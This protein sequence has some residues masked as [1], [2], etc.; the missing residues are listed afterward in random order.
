MDFDIVLVGGGLANGLLA[1][2]LSQ[3]RPDISVAIVEGGSRIGGNHIWSSLDHDLSPEQRAW[4]EPLIAHR[5]QEY[6]VRFPKR[7]RTLKAGYRTATSG[8]LAD[9]MEAALPDGHVST[10]MKAVALDATS[11]TLAD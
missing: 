11:V 10:D 5:W 3:L 9:A 6:S 2:R 8:L 1:L 7:A 4:T